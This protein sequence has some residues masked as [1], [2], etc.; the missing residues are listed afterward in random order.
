MIEVGSLVVKVKWGLVEYLKYLMV[1]V[2]LGSV[3]S[4]IIFDL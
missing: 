2:F 4:Q 3:I 1:N